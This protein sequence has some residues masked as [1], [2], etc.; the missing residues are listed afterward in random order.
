MVCDCS[1]GVPKTVPGLIPKDDWLERQSS[2]IGKSGSD[3]GKAVRLKAL[4]AVNQAAVQPPS[5]GKAAPL[6]DAPASEAR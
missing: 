4:R 2:S 1:P 3:P 6:Q 5:T